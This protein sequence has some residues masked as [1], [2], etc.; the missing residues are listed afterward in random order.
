MPSDSS[1]LFLVATMTALMCSHAFPASGS[2]MMPRKAWPRPVR[3]L[4]SRMQPAR[5][6]GQEV[7]TGAIKVVV[8][9]VGAAAGLEDAAW[10]V[11]GCACVC[12]GAAIQVEGRG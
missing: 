9:V 2:T 3:A 10:E 1:I 6:G 11:W 4:N 12:L 5:C 8:V 7:R